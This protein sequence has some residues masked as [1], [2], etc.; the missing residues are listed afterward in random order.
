MNH[1]T[2]V[3]R[4]VPPQLWIFVVGCGLFLV[5]PLLPWLPWLP[6]NPIPPTA[7]LVA[8]F[9]MQQPSRKMYRW[10]VGFALA[11]VAYPFLVAPGWASLFAPDSRLVLGVIVGPVLLAA[12]LFTPPVRRFLPD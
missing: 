8:S 10:T 1:T 5:L 4:Y 3:S 7:G 9:L 12:L 2:L 11:A 6:W